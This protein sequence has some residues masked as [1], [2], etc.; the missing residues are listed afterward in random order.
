MG[1]HTHTAYDYQLKHK[2]GSENS[3]DGLSRLPLISNDLSYVPADIDML[4]SIIEN[5]VVNACDVKRETQKDECLVKVYEY[6][7][8]G[9]PEESVSNDFKPYK[10]R[11]TELSLENGCILWGSRVVIPTSL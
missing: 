4:F 11:K 2:P 6:C 1:Y 5:S 3:A 8:N 9:W 10:N 7:L